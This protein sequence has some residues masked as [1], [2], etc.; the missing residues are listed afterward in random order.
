MNRLEV[1]G[2]YVCCLVIIV[3]FIG[4]GGAK[5]RGFKVIVLREAKVGT[6]TV[7]R[8]REIFMRELNA[9]LFYQNYLCEPLLV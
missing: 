3:I 8:G 9:K 4:L 2:N 6:H 5:G 1:R 7:K